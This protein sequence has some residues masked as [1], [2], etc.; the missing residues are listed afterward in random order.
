MF[1]KSENSESKNNISK[2]KNLNILKGI[3]VSSG[4]WSLARFRQ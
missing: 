1:E 2:S 3:C 4:S